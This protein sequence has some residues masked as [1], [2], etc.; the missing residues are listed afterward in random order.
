MLYFFLY[1]VLTNLCR[2]LFLDLFLQK[3]GVV[4]SSFDPPFFVNAGLDVFATGAMFCPLLVQEIG[5]G[6]GPIGGGTVKGHRVQTRSTKFKVDNIES[7]RQMANVHKRSTGR[8]Q[9][10]A[11]GGIL[12]SVADW[13]VGSEAGVGHLFWT[14]WALYIE[15]FSHS[16][17]VVLGHS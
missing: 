8:N 6:A 12:T 17:S 3:R 13:V 16:C 1:M 11:S 7:F 9:V 4:V 10:A 2:H 15:F 5:T 14:G